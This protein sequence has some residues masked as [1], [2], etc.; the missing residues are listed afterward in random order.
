MEN[1]TGILGGIIINWL[2]DFVEYFFTVMNFYEIFAYLALYLKAFSKVLNF[3]L[4]LLR[5]A[6]GFII[7]TDI[8]I[9]F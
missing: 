7:I 1:P 3:F 9:I 6:V 4:N 5:K 8:F 2:I